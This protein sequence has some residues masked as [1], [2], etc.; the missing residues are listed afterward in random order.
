[1]SGVKERDDCAG[2]GVRGFNPIR[3][4]QVTAGTGPGKVEYVRG[5]ASRAWEDVLDMEGGSL[6]RLV[7]EAV[8]ATPAGTGL[9]QPHGRAPGAHAGFR[10]S[11]CR[12]LARTNAMVSL[13]STRASK[14]SFSPGVRVPFVLRSIKACKRRSILGGRCRAA[15]ASSISTGA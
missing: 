15:T 7:H 11:V 9:H 8:F 14:S 10:P 13:S 2:V 12:A 4:P 3:L 6:E 5:A 1:R